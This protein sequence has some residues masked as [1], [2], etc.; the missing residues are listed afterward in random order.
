MDIC[1]LTYCTSTT[2]CSVNMLTF[3]GV[4]CTHALWGFSPNTTTTYLLAM[5]I[6][7]W[8]LFRNFIVSLPAGWLSS[9]THHQWGQ[10]RG[11]PSVTAVQ[12]PWLQ[13]QQGAECMTLYHHRCDDSARHAVIIWESICELR[14]GSRCSSA[15]GQYGLSV[16]TNQLRADERLSRQTST[17]RKLKVTPSP[18]KWLTVQN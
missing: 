15:V 3:I 2:A 4:I 11:G 1:G 6:E 16:T 8:L 13:P 12:T 17:T 5:T 9:P 7:F 18:V 10:R 14:A